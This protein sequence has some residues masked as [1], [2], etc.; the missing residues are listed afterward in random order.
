MTFKE[1]KATDWIPEKDGDCI[2]GELL[3]I[4]PDVGVNKAIVYSIQTSS[5]PKNVWGSVILDS[6]MTLVKQGSQV[7]ITY[8][9]LAQPQK[10]KKAAKIFKVEVDNGD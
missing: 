8:K 7:R 3:H 1:V 10:G 6:L 5:G 2:E 9:G 4:K